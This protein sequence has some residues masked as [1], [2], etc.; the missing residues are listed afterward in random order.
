MLIILF[1]FR[2]GDSILGDEIDKEWGKLKKG[3]EFEEIISDDDSKDTYD[4][5]EIKG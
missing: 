5:V 1:Y 3:S 2:W 4:R